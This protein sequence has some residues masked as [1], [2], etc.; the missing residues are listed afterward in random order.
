MSR[1]INL[2]AL[3]CRLN[4]AELQQWAYNFQA[5]GFEITSEPETAD[6]VVVNTC[7]VTKEA[8]RKSR[9]FIRRAHRQNPAARLVVSGCFATLEQEQ[10]ASIEGVDLVVVNTNKDDLVERTTQALDLQTMPV[11][12][13][14]PAEA[15][16][17]QHGRTRAFIKVQDGCRW[18]CTYCIVTKARGDERSRP[19]GEVIEQ[20]NRLYEQG[21]HEVVL[22]GVHLGGYGSDIDDDLFHLTRQVLESTDVPRIRFGSLEPWDIH[23]EFFQL[24]DDQ[25]LMPHLHLPLQSGADSVLKRMARRCQASDF[26]TLVEDARK[27]IPDLNIT[28][29]I[30][31]GFPGESEDEWR[32][33]LSYIESVGFG[34]VHIFAFSPRQGTKA[35]R[36]PNQV[37]KTVVKARSAEL[38]QLSTNM[39]KSFEQ[40]FVGTTTSI[41]VEDT[42]QVLGEDRFA[43]Y[44]YTPNYIRVMIESRQDD[45]GGLLLPVRLES[46]QALTDE[47]LPTIR[48][49]RIK[50]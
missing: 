12:A 10:A 23:P 36:L 17:F 26:K 40:G 44:G 20:I 16:L 27:H 33:G 5:R 3:G 4:E 30:I 13:Q 29:D 42:V 6:L 50:C 43:Y 38:H 46:H 31:V 11:I 8:A 48:A 47:D 25:R 19:A 35:A 34:H 14:R 45:L 32:L 21:V 28:T 49:R 22:T 1:R 39:K 7:A 9:Q 41:L 37:E 24:F 2:Q 15:A 18:R